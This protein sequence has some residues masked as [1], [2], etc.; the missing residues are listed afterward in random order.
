[1]NVTSSMTSLSA[2]RRAAG[3]H[4][5]TEV[6]PLFR[7]STRYSYLSASTGLTFAAR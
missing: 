6:G 5:P 2:A 7:P 3:G 1:M 4:I